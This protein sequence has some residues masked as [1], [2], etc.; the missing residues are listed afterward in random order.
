L[1]EAQLAPLDDEAAIESLVRWK[2]IGRWTAEVALIRGLGRL[3][4]FPAGDLAVLK[5]LAPAWLGRG[6]SEA[7]VRDFAGRWRPYRSLALVYAFEAMAAQAAQ[8]KPRSAR[9]A[10]R[11]SRA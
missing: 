3:D 10:A 7:D 4:V 6:A 9:R 5:R 1:S 8:R 11:R 2:G